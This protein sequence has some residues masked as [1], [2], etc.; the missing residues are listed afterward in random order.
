MVEKELPLSSSEELILNF[1]A[2]YSVYFPI[3]AGVEKVKHLKRFSCFQHFK[4]K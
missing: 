3:N 4:Q 1:L 2:L